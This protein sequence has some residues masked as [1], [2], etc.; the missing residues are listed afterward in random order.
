[1][2]AT[3]QASADGT[4]ESVVNAR[5][6]V[7]DNSTDFVDLSSG[8]TLVASA[9][10]QS[11]VLS[12]SQS[13]GE[14]RYAT[15]FTGLDSAGM[16]YTVA[17]NRANDVSAPSSTCTLPTPFQITSP[18]SDGTFSRKND[19]IV[20]S[21]DHA[22]SMDSMAWSVSGACIRTGA[23]GIV[24]GD[25]GS[26]TIAR[27]SLTSSDPAAAGVTCQIQVTL[28]RSRPGELDSHFGAGGSIVAQ[29]V[30]AVTFNSAP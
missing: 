16:L 21:Y 23:N 20:V 15:S 11:R 4:G 1:M 5:L 13:L 27:G 8:D 7:D 17:L 3:I 19:D 6:N 18:N 2:S 12:R 25:A 26:F 10:G 28:T 22:G 14:V 24:G 9:G 29:Q 30:R